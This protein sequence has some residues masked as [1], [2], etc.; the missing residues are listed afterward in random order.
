MSKYNL[1]RN[2]L[3]YSAYS[4]WHKD[5]DQFRRRY[6]L[7]EKPFETVETIFGKTVHDLK[8][9]DDS[10]IGSETSIQITIDNDLN[11]LGY[12]DSFNEETLAIVDFKSGHLDSKGKAPWDRVKVQKHKQLVFYSLLVLKKHG[13][14]NPVTRLI[15]LET[16]FKRVTR[17]M[18]GH[19]LEA[20]SRELHLTGYEKTF[21][22]KIYK[23]EIENLRKDIIK[24]A[25]Q[26]SDD[27]T[28]WQKNQP[29]K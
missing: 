7:N 27:Y 10:V 22:R 25:K 28:L 14:Y 8:E 17:E 19:V 21:T 11:L 13:K 2:Y 6:Y 26:I 15:W 23:Y 16:E 29:A 18:D 1:P 20:E 12:L 24:T 3:S 5:K 4:L 9:K